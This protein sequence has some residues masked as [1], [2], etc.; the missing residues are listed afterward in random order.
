[1]CPDRDLLSAHADGEVPSPWR[2]RLEEHIASCA[3]CAGAMAGYAAL[4]DA[5]RSGEDA[6]EAAAVSRGRARLDA[7]LDGTFASAPASSQ[8]PAS[9][10]P[11]LSAARAAFGRSIRLPLPFAAA[12]ALIVLLLGGAT[13]VLA[14]RPDRG[15]SMPTIAAGELESHL[16]KPASMDEL[17]RFLGSSDGQVQVTINLPSGTTFGSA[18]SPVIMRS[19]Q[20]APGTVMG[21]SSP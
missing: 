2:E 3:D 13:A 11:K 6:E 5:L 14:F 10:A 9:P 20:V 16:A 15:S 7:L 17:L 12:A 18:G 4:R 19:D 1:V 21:D 8:R